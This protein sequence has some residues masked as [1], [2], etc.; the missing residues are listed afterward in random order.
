MAGSL[1]NV[2]IQWGRRE[3]RYHCL[4]RNSLTFFGRRKA[5]RSPPRPQSARTCVCV[6][7][8]GASPRLCNS[9]SR[10]AVGTWNLGKF[11]PHCNSRLR[12]TAHL[13]SPQ[14]TCPAPLLIKP[15]NIPHVHFHQTQCT[16]TSPPEEVPETSP[17]LPPTVPKRSH[18]SARGKRRE[19]RAKQW[20]RGKHWR[21]PRG[22]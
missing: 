20:P 10:L 22:G 12:V 17:V 9:R 8:G 5:L 19:G 1:E 3:K 2:P 4:R 15:P 6:A 11:G 7:V 14:K 16:S 18:P 13:T 21:W